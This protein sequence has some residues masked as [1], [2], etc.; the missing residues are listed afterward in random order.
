[1]EKAFKFPV[2]YVNGFFFKFYDVV[3]MQY[4]WLE[5]KFDVKTDWFFLR[6]VDKHLLAVN[7]I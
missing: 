5:E 3:C 7:F 6:T 4:I 2:Q 1:M